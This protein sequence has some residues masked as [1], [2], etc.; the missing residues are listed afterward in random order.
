VRAFIVLSQITNQPYAEPRDKF[1]VPRIEFRE[2]AAAIQHSFTDASA[3]QRLIT[4][5]ITEI[6]TIRQHR[7]SLP[8]ARQ[9]AKQALTAQ[10]RNSK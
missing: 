10:Q 1:M 7:L 2:R 3:I 5:K 9:V 8:I 4:A 6:W